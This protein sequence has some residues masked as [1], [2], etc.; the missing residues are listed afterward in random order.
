M[1][2]DSGSGLFVPEDVPLEKHAG[3]G[4]GLELIA[5]TLREGPAGLELYVAVRNDGVMSACDAAMTVEFFDQT[6]L[7]LAAW[8]G[9][10]YSGQLYRASDGS[11]TTVACLDPDEV[12]MGGSTTL[13]ENVT[14]DAL[15]Y[16]V[17]RISY[18]DRDFLPF[19]VMPLEGLSVGPIESVS[20]PTG[21][22]F[23][24]ALD[25]GLEEAVDDPTVA[26]FPVNDAGRPLGMATSS[27][28]VE[29][30]PGASWMFETTPVDDP[31]F[32]QV[33][34]AGASIASAG[35]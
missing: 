26:V 23:R 8:I 28:M 15:S 12:A 29:I 30:E 7:S 32:K 18:F 25:N 31:G 3:S 11:D 21:T 16:A 35:D 6:D 24:G 1:A 22:T 2:G 10:L 4:A 34:Y 19:E 17:Y 27:A 13:P 20:G 14:L 33:V 5:A 9:G